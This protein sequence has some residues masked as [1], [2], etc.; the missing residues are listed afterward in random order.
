MDR[1]FRLKI[2]KET[3]ALRDTIDQ[4]GL[5]DIY[6]TFHPKVAECTLFSSTHGTFSRIDHMVGHKTSLSEFK[7]IKFLSSIFPDHT[8]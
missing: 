6:R 1:S 7:K 5:I 3:R 2:N 8:Q 4:M